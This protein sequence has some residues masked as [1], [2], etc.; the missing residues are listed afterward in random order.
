M[1]IETKR[2]LLRSLQRSD[3]EPLCRIWAD[4]QV[5]RYMGGPRDPEDVR[6][7]L[8]EDLASDSPP[9]FDL[10][11]VIE[12]ATGAVVG[13]CGLLEKEVDGQDEIELVYVLAAPAWGKGYAT[14]VGIAIRDYAFGE[15]ALERIISLI[16]PENGAS[17]RV[18]EKVGLRFEK[19]TVRP[20]GKTMH[21]YT[22]GSDR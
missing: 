10:W 22:M 7:I 19:E 1:H 12:K 6:A 3:I 9:D 11:P 8:E 20:G 21:V 4:P 15:L 17:Q 2:L 18:A 14:E 13:D 5:T 16:D